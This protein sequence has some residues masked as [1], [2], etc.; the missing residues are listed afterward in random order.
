MAKRSLAAHGAE[1]LK[2]VV[3]Q[4]VRPIR[5]LWHEVIG[6]LFL[7]LAVWFG[8]AAVRSYMHVGEQDDAILRLVMAGFLTIVMGW[9]GI[10]SFLRA[11]KISRS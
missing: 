1:F 2:H 9:F 7:V 10:T 6:F 11:R 8:S 4:L 3:P 5:S